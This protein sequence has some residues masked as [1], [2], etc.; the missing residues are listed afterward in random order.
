[1]AETPRPFGRNCGQRSEDPAGRLG[2]LVIQPGL[3]KE[4]RQCLQPLHEECAAPIASIAP[5]AAVGVRAGHVHDQ[6][7][8]IWLYKGRGGHAA[9]LF[10]EFAV[11]QIEAA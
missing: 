2:I 7:I 9:A 10:T 5:F 3:R 4:A 1:M 8:R 6:R 11:I